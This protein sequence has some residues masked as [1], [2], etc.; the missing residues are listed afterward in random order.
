MKFDVIIPA[1]DEAENVGRIIGIFRSWPEVSGIYLVDNASRDRTGE[2][3]RKA[4]ATVVEEHRVGKGYAVQTG[5]KAAHSQHV[6][7]CD[8]DIHGLIRDRVLEAVESV[9]S[10]PASLCRLVMTRDIEAAPVTTL[11]A[12]PCLRHLFPEMNVQEPLGGL[13]AIAR[14][15]ALAYRLVGDWG[16]DVG[17]TLSVHLQGRTIHEIAAPELSH[18]TRALG[19]YEK[20]AYEVTQTILAFA[21]GREVKS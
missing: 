1:K 2:L 9:A 8:A 6:F 7:V 12:K 14:N 13:F 17:L 5:L 18:R 10:G 3:A 15:E 21:D 4:G 16:F 11:V 19:E 20:M